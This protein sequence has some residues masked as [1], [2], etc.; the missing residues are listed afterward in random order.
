MTHTLQHAATNYNTL[1]MYQLLLQYCITATTSIRVS[2]DSHSATRCNKLQHT[3]YVPVIVAVL[4][5]RAC[6]EQHFAHA[7]HFICPLFHLGV[8]VRVCA[9]V[10]VCMCVCTQCT[11]S[12]HFST[13]VCT[14]A[15]VR[16]CV[17]VC[18]R[19]CVCACVCPRNILHLPTFPPVCACVHLCVCVCVSARVRVR[20]CVCVR[21]RMRVCT[22]VCVCM[23]VGVCICLGYMCVHLSLTVY[24]ICREV[25]GWGRVPLERW[26]AGVEY[27][28][29]EFN[30]PYAPS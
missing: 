18:V 26:G 10:R 28:F 17:C 11:P 5:H 30:E 6:V 29:Q 1:N 20:V 4:H 13:C 14:C 12:T 21:A 8:C 2:Y 9:C 22:C 7:I 19:V 23:Y 24:F 15:C 25:G 16:V 3:E 27:H